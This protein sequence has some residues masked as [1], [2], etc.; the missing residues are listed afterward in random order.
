MENAQSRNAEL[1]TK[2]INV[3]K[4]LQLEEQTVRN[5]QNKLASLKESGNQ[6]KL[7]TTEAALLSQQMKVSSLQSEVDLLKSKLASER[8]KHTIRIDAEMRKR[9]EVEDA[10]AESRKNLQIAEQELLSSQEKI[11]SLKSEVARLAS[12][13]DSDRE[14]YQQKIGDLETEISALTQK[15]ETAES[16]ITATPNKPKGFVLSEEWQQYKQWITPSQMRF[17]NI[18]HEY[19]IARVEA[20]NSGNQLLQNMAIKQRDKD[21][22]ALLTSSRT[23]QSGEG[24]RNWVSI[25]QS[26]FAMD[27]VNPETGNTELAAGV[28]LETPCGISVGTGRVLDTADAAKSE[29]KYLAFEGDLIF[30]QLASVRRGDPVL[31][32]GSFARSEAGSS[33]MFITNELGEEERLEAYEKPDDAPDMF[34]DI[35]YL[36]KL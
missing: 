17:C 19:E 3:N 25:V 30:S 7:E 26:V 34:V 16:Q 35:S 5:L 22:S 2:V 29:F 33:E 23:G 36:A 9:L 15:L 1:N 14:S 20:A 27:S 21:I 12:A 6:E 8:E 24:F 11:S 4:K 10:I 31:F 28:I 18:L 32:D 13:L